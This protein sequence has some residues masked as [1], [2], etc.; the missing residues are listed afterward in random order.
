MVMSCSN[1]VNSVGLALDIIGV[2]LIW[3]FGLPAS[4]SRDGHDYLILE[5]TN[6][7]EKRKALTYD[8][9]SQ[10]GLALVVAGFVFQLA[11]NF[12]SN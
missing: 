11:S 2:I 12:I 4:L 6:E 9:L 1:I 3:R 5:S 8:H 7:P 10:F